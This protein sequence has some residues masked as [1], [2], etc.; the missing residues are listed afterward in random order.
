MGLME[1]LPDSRLILT[2]H[3]VT[4][5][6]QRNMPAELREGET[7]AQFLARTVPEDMGYLW[8]VRINGV[9]VQHEVMDRVRPKPGTVIEVRSVVGNQ[10]LKIVAFAALTY[11]TFGFGT[12]TAGAWGAGAAASAF[13]GGLAGALFA[14]AV[15]TAGS[16]LINKVLG[17]KLLGNSTRDQN[18]VYSIGQSRN[19][20]R[21][22]QPLPL[23]FGTVRYAPDILS[24][25]YWWFEGND[26]Y[27]GM[28][29]TPGINAHSVEALY[30]G[31]TALSTYEG[32]RVY[33]AG[34]PGMASEQIPLYSNADTIAGGELEKDVW[35]QRTTSS[36]T[37]R[38]QVNL[39]YVLGD[40]TSKGKPKR[41]T[42]YV[43]VQYRQTGTTTWLQSTSRMFVNKTYDAKRAT[44]SFDVPAGQYDVRVRRREGLESSNAKAQFQWSTMTCVQRDTADYAGIPRIGVR[45]KA[46]DQLPGGGLD[47]LRCVVHSRPIPVW[48]GSDW[49]TEESSNPGAQILAYARG[50]EDENGRR[51][52]GIG[53]PDSMIDIP[54]LQAFML[55]CAAIVSAKARSAKMRFTPVCASSKLPFT[56]I[57]WVFAPPVV[58]ICRRC[59]WLTPSRG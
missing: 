38:I 44:L 37:V 29:L 45:I 19:Q 28:V 53:L 1:P 31:E 17:P 40:V 7:L 6:G 14:T 23:V 34:F 42:A 46:S 3:P 22:Y 11:F 47:E 51:I 32:V 35:V 27:L 15:Y 5:D 50:I 10:S 9:L 30:N 2:P 26:Q 43:D 58:T 13:G 41:N 36:N 24:N 56:A 12:A 33:H 49:V 48:N 16:M 8:E 20:A 39:E 25:P 55:H 59:A 4:L 18:P 52:A 54:A 21:Q 57:T